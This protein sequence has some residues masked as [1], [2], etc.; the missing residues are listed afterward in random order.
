MGCDLW[1][2]HGPPENL[3]D[4]WSSREF[5]SSFRQNATATGSMKLGK[6][7]AGESPAPTA[8][9]PQRPSVL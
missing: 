1:R 2:T 4:D 3:L 7:V 5:L 9:S 8:L 6:T